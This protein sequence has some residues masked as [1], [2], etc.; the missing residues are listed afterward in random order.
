VNDWFDLTAFTTPTAYNYGNSGRD[1]LYG[2]GAVNFDWSIFKR[3]S[4]PWL[5]EAAQV[6]LRLEGFNIFNHP[7]F[8]TPAVNV[9]TAA[10]GSITFLT[11]S[12][13]VFQAGLKV[14]F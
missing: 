8:G 7:Q 2:P 12:M 5:G 13:R 10:A 11:H 6:Q 1:I 4:V 3:H 9:S 14:V